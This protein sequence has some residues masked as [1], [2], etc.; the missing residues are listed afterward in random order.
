MK[1]PRR[2]I[3]TLVILV[4]FVGIGV[5]TGVQSAAAGGETIIAIPTTTPQAANQARGISFNLR[6]QARVLTASGQPVSGATVTFTAPSS[7]PRATFRACGGSFSDVEATAANGIATSARVCS[8]GTT[9]SVS[10]ISL[11]TR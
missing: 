5:V 10:G 7:G 11:G 8:L 1:A 9:G 6:L 4:T 3:T 2:L